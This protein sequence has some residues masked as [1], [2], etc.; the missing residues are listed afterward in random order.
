MLFCVVKTPVAGERE[1]EAAETL[2]V[3]TRENKK[4]ATTIDNRFRKG[5][6]SFSCNPSFDSDI[7]YK[8]KY[9]LRMLD[10]YYSRT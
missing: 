4:Q 10:I 2:V 5:K 8:I 1:K 7:K 3:I 9:R 6:L